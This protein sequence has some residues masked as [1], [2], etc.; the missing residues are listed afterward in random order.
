MRRLRALAAVGAVAVAGLLV[1]ASAGGLAAPEKPTVNTDILVWSTET[2]ATFELS[3]SVGTT[4]FSCRLDGGGSDWAPCTSPVSYTSLSEGGHTF[5]VRALDASGSQS[6]PT[7]V[8]WTIDVTP[9]TL[10]VDVVAEAT[11]PAGAIVV[12]AAADNLDPSPDLSCT[13]SPGSTFPLG[14]TAVAC[15]AEDAA[16]NVN[17]GG[18]FTVTVRDTTPPTLESHAD[19]IA[20]QQSPQGA[21]VDYALPDAK[22]AAD[23]SPVVRCDPAPGGL[24]PLGETSVECVATDASGLASAKETFRVIVQ[25]GPTPAKPGITTSVPR[26]TTRAEAEFELSVGPGVTTECRLDGPLG[27]GSFEPCSGDSVKTY[28]GL[29]DGAY[30]FTVQVTNSVGNVNQASFD[31][32]VDRTPPAAV[33]GFTAR[34]D[35]RRVS[36]AWT[37]PIDV[38]YDRVRIWRK[39]GAAGA[40]TR[41]AD[42]VAADSFID[43]TVA[44]HVLYRYRIQSFD[45][46]GNLSAAAEVA[47][48]PSP[49]VSPAYNAV[50]HSPPLL[51]WRSVP[52]A[53]YY[54]L[55]VWRN[56]K[57]VLSVWPLRSQYR[58]RSSWTFRGRRYTLSAGRVAV[59]VWPGFGSK[60]AAR[61]GPLY[62]RTVFTIG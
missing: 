44:N 43:R 22:D 16:G 61:Y 58:L 38:D 29:V 60:A 15:T 11:S 13:H 54:N 49:I 37:T 34:A 27:G 33:A 17:A 19:V 39:R 30:L 4:G 31:W 7:T 26:L 8:G 40:W 41:L 12:F 10:P 45:K 62:G 57:K 21:V 5:Q 51:D 2:S 47:A 1:S 56:G 6:P 18:A 35:H 36:L 59:F 24:F 46:A 50:V 14:A 9:P 52:R 42:R 48:W 23:P 55:Q 28:S 53:T 32:T 25:A 3:G 20:A